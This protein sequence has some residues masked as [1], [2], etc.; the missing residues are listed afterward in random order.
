MYARYDGYGKVAYV[1]CTAAG[2]PARS[3]WPLD[4]PRTAFLEDIHS[5]SRVSSL[6][7]I[8]TEINISNACIASL[9]CVNLH[10]APYSGTLL[11]SES[12]VLGVILPS[13]YPRLVGVRTVEWLS[14]HHIHS[15]L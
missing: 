5:A 10:L 13:A 8:P 11:E 15:F 4:V 2:P 12:W 6:P 3:D 7:C 14:L 9:D 1:Y